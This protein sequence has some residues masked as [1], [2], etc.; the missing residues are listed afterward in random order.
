MLSDLQAM[1]KQQAGAT[2][3][4]YGLILALISLAA[5]LTFTAVGNGIG[6]TLNTVTSKLQ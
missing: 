6:D 3:I 5:I 1:L 4:E 2:A